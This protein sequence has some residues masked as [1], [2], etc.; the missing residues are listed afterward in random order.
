LKI[1]AEPKKTNELCFL[2]LLRPGR[3]LDNSICRGK[4]SAGERRA[5]N[6]FFVVVYTLADILPFRRIVTREKTP[7]ESVDGKILECNRGHIE[8]LEREQKLPCYGCFAHRAIVGADA[9]AQL[10]LQHLTEG[11]F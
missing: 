7:F 8:M 10:S 1:K 11:M 4:K 9:H 3:G 5:A 6:Q 2:L